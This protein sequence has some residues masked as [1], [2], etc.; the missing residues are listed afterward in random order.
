M[1]Y[2][3][4]ILASK[5]GGTLYIGTTNDLIRRIHEHR[6]AAVPGFTKRYKIH[7]LVYFEEH[8]TSEQAIR[9]EKR[10]KTW[11]RIWKVQLIETDN[12]DWNDLYPLLL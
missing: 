10:L 1:P 3:T 4:Y 5:P 11:L 12:P 7:H 8:A 6:E 2:Y 9:R